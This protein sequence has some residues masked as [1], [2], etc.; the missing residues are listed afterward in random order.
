MQADIPLQGD[1]NTAVGRSIVGL[2]NAKAPV[3]SDVKFVSMRSWAGQDIS[4]LNITRPTQPTILAVPHALVER[5]AFTFARMLE[6]TSNPWA[7]LEKPIENDEVPVIADDETA[8]YILK[9]DLGGTMPLVDQAGHARKLKLVATLGGSIFQSEMLM[10]EANFLK[11]FPTQSGYSMV[12]VDAP[13]AVADG[14]LHDL[15]R[16]LDEYSVSAETTAQRLKAFNQVADTYLSTFQ[17][18]G[19]LGL[20]LGTIGLAVVLIR[21]LIERRSELAILAALGFG[22]RER[23]RLVLAENVWL[24]LLG[25]AAGTGCAWWQSRR[26]CRSVRGASIL[27]RW[28][29]WWELFW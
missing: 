2:T 1:L 14:L 20:M 27:W 15:P 16:E 4:C 12:L 11:L 28:R 24:L 25:L 17:A 10:G 13:A 9:L 8:Q 7:L 23:L 6:K 5:N 21:S 22:R 26:R 29:G 19:A 18:L 3:W